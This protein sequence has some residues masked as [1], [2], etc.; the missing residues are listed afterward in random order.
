ML[1][2]HAID[3]VIEPVL[4]RRLFSTSIAN[5]DALPQLTLPPGNFACLLAW[6]ARD[7]SVDNVSAL[8]ESLLHQGASCFVCWGPDCER[9]HDIIDEIV[10][11][12]D[13]VFDVPDDACIMT[14]WHASAPLAE[15]IWF[16]LVNSQP[17]KHYED[18]THTA[19]A[20]TIGSPAWASQIAEA[21]D[22]PSDFVERGAENDLEESKGLGVVI[23]TGRMWIKN[24]AAVPS[25]S[26]PINAEVVMKAISKYNVA[27]RMTFGICGM[28]VLACIWS[29]AG[30]WPMRHLSHRESAFDQMENLF[31]IAPMLVLLWFS[32]AFARPKVLPLIAAIAGTFCYLISYVMIG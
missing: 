21:L 11:Y 32:F 28:T 1:R 16:F 6:D 3:S 23:L 31:S 9:V 29:I 30:I 10:S 2:E 14:M 22:D 18:S 25:F 19:L 7:V 17:N 20:I 24:R 8:V 13:N 5:A 12:P 27:A 15:A 26:H 4:E